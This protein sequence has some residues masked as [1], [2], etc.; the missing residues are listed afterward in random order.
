MLED[1]DL[2]LVLLLNKKNLY[3]KM[4]FHVFFT[5]NQSLSLWAETNVSHT[6]AF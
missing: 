1:L 3:S 4:L 2:E 6:P 5:E